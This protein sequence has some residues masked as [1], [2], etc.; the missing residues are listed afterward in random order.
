MTRAVLAAASRVHASLGNEQPVRVYKD[1]ISSEFRK[2]SIVFQRN[3]EISDQSICGILACMHRADFLCYDNL[4]VELVGDT[5]ITAKDVSEA[6]RRLHK[7]G[8]HR[9]LLLCLGSNVMQ[10]EKLIR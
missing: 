4:M 7:S 10:Y 2:H 3:L 1:A 9:A 8:L 6:S 5:N